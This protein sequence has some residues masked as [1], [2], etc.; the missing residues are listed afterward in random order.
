[1]HCVPDRVFS[2]A[3]LRLYRVLEEMR[4]GEAYGLAILNTRICGELWLPMV[5]VEVAWRN[6][7]D[8]TMTEQ[9]PAESGWLLAEP[10]PPGDSRFRIDGVRAPGWL[11]SPEADDLDSVRAAADA[12]AAHV[13]GHAGTMSRDDLVAHLMF[14]F[15][16]LALPKRALTHEPPIDLYEHASGVLGAEDEALANPKTLRGR[17]TEMVALR[18][19]I[20]HHESVVFRARSVF[21]KAGEQQPPLAILRNVRAGLDDFD[22]KVGRLVALATALAPLSAEMLGE[23]TTSIQAHSAPLIQRLDAAEEH[24]RAER[25]RRR[26]ESRPS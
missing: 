26:P 16:A 6:L 17:F 1:M 11:Y 18:N 2:T 20:A 14:G 19:R 4:L 10:P 25:S 9:H 7:I 3:R 15:W 12:F 8:R 23:I 5:L 21:S 13:Q 24:F 22:G